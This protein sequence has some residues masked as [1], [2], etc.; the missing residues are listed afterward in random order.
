MD[1]LDAN[2]FN[3]AIQFNQPGQAYDFAWQARAAAANFQIPYVKERTH[4]ALVIDPTG[5]TVN[6]PATDDSMCTAPK[7][8]FHQPPICAPE[9]TLCG[10]CATQ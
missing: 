8:A 5:T 4:R 3:E 9:S 7:R 2:L 6:G 1:V 10:L